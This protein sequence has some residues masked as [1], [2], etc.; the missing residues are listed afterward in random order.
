MEMLIT[1]IA[2]ETRLAIVGN[3]AFI[4]TIILMLLLCYKFRKLTLCLR[5][6]L[7]KRDK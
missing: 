7:Q 1:N 2:L 4:E 6:P 3:I 5:H